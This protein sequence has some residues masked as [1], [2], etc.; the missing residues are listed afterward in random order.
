MKI[1]LIKK[2]VMT[3]NPACGFVTKGVENRYTVLYF[4][5]FP[6]YRKEELFTD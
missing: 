5:G 3:K 6:V 4:L 1:C 2:I